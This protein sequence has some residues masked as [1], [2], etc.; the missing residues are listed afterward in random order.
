VKLSAAA[1]LGAVLL[2]LLWSAEQTSKFVVKLDPDNPQIVELGKTVYE[3][4]CASCHGANLEGEPNWKQRK[5]NGRMPAPPH[6]ASGPTWHHPGQTLFA[7]T[8]F[9]PAAMAGT[10]TYKSDMPAYEDTLTNEE[11]VA[12]L[13]F[14]KNRWPAGIRQRHDEMERRITESGQ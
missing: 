3:E 4:Q 8:K 13:S 2:Y 1:V 7:V 12:V 6:D 14:I 5:P 11:I 9:G 10:G